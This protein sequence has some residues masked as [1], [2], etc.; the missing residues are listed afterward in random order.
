MATRATIRREIARRLNMDFALRV[1]ESA[2]A[3]GGTTTTLID[4]AMLDQ[5]DD[6]W[7]G[8]W[9]YVVNDAD[10]STND[11]KIRLITDF[12]QSSSTLTFLR[13]SVRHQ[14]RQILTKYT[15]VG[16]QRK[17]TVLSTPL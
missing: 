6:Y 9:L 12:T 1:G 11:G 8:D 14:P 15:Q 2:T 3:T 13:R 17:F 16:T 5:A 10:A 4:T 7:N